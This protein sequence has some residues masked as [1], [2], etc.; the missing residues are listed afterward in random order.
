MAKLTK[1]QQAFQGKVEAGMQQTIDVFEAMD[2][3][4]AAAHR[5]IEKEPSRLDERW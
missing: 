3:Q 1:R 2:W 4:T 5:S